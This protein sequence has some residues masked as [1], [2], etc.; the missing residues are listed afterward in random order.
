MHQKG[1][2]MSDKNASCLQFYNHASPDLAG[3]SALML[4]LIMPL[5]PNT[6]AEGRGRVR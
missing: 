3:T 1:Y 6:N 5:V 2:P 4:C